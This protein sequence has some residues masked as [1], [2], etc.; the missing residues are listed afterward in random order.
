[1][2]DSYSDYYRELKELDYDLYQKT[3]IFSQGLIHNI[4]SGVW[5]QNMNV[6]IERSVVSFILSMKEKQYL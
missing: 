1:M 2:K 6:C 5:K 3:I 4:E